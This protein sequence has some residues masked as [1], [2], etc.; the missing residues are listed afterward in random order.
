M[1]LESMQ[2]VYFALAFL[3]PGFVADLVLSTFTTRRA[4]K[5]ETALLRYLSLSALNY[6]VWSW[7]VY[8][9]VTVEWFDRH[10]FAAG[11]AWLFVILGGPTILAVAGGYSVQRDWGRKLCRKLDLHPVHIIPTAW[12]YR[13]GSLKTPH[14][15]HVTLKDGSV[16]AGY[17]GGAS[18]ASSSPQERDLYIEQLW[19]VPD[20][21]HWVRA[22]EGK[23]ILLMKDD[24]RFIE[25]WPDRREENGNGERQ[26]ER[27]PAPEG[28]SGLGVR[29]ERISAG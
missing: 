1:K 11:M 6:A 25:I 22:A 15:V 3:V 28:T 20:A 27:L 5:S 14:W 17:F 18:F 21:G 2:A 16:V 29:A 8:L 12:D 26:V 7:L 13:F 24:I 4:E 10:P 23:V 19:T 9:V